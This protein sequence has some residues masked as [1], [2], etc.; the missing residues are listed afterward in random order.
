MGEKRNGFK[1]VI[2]KHPDGYV[3]CPLGLK[4]VVVGEGDTYEAALENVKGRPFGSPLGRGMEPRPSTRLGPRVSPGPWQPVKVA[5]M[6]A[7]EPLDGG[8]VEPGSGLQ[9]VGKA[10]DGKGDFF[11]TAKDVG[12]LQ[13][14]VNGF[15]FFSSLQNVFG[16]CQGHNLEKKWEA[17]GCEGVHINSKFFLA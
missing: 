13:R 14:D 3:A 15:V 7:G 9:D 5:L 6:N 16:R 17:S 2:E 1:L 11:Q 8:A 4:G 12:E 10:L